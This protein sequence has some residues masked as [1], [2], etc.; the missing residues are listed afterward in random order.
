MTTFSNLNAASVTTTWNGSTFSNSQSIT[1]PAGTSNLVLRMTGVTGSPT[2]TFNSVAVPRLIRTGDGSIDSSYV[3]VLDAPDI[4]TY[5]LVINSGA[6]AR[7]YQTSIDVVSG[8]VG[9][10]TFDGVGENF[11]ADRSLTLTTG[12][13]DLVLD[14][15]V[16][17]ST[18]TVGPGQTASLL[19]TNNASF[20]SEV[21]TTTSTTMSWTHAA[22]WSALTAVVFPEPA[23]A[24]TPTDTNYTPGETITFSTTLTSLTGATLEGANGNVFTLTGVTDTTVAVPALAAALDACLLGAVTLSVTDGTDTATASIT[25]DPPAGYTVTDLTAITGDP[26]F[27]TDVTPQW[28]NPAEIGDQVLKNEPRLTVNPDLSYS[29]TGTT[30]FTAVVW[31]I[32]FNGGEVTQI[33]YEFTVDTDAV[34][35]S[36]AA[37][38]L[39]SASLVVVPASSGFDGVLSATLTILPA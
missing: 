3:F 30:A 2:V 31:V 33:T 6:S 38:A 11:A 12:V 13:G 21:A 14:A 34:T 9:A 7:T 25:L 1:T 36:D 19:N 24:L 39:D 18:A 4:G 26:N 23:F 15:L 20:S 35:G 32:S 29:V 28:T 37:N 27:A 17:A 8:S 22:N 10:P 16:T 5:D